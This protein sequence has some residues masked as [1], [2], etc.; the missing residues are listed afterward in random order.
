MKYIKFTYFLILFFLPFSGRSQVPVQVTDSTKQH[1]FTF[2]EI[3]MLVDPDDNYSFEE[4]QSDEFRTK[5]KASIAN[6]PQTLALNTNYWF[7][8]SIEGSSHLKNNFI[9]EFFDQTI[10]EITVYT[11]LA[12]GRYNTFKIGDH[13]PFGQRFL[14]HKNFEIPL[15]FNQGTNEQV[16]YFKIKSSQISDVIIVLRSV[17]FF[18]AYALNE[19]FSFGIFYGMILVFSL[20]NLIL[21]IS[22]RQKQYLFYVLYLLSVAL[23]EMSSDGIAYQYLWPNAPNWNQIAFAFTLI[24]ASS[25][26]LLFT[27]ELFHFKERVPWIYKLILYTLGI[28]AILFIYSLAFNQSFFNYKFIEFI[29]LSVAFFAG[30]YVYF[31]G[32][33]AARFFVIGYGFIFIGFTIKLLIMLGI[34]QLNF[35]VIG[36]YSLSICFILEMIFFSLA[37]GDNLRILKIKQQKMQKQVLKQMTENAALKDTLNRE[38]KSEVRKRNQELEIANMQLQQQ[39]EEIFRMNKLLQL[40]KEELQHDKEELLT[41]VKKISRDRAL[42]AEVD[43]EEFSA[44]YPDA[45]SCYEFLSELKWE[46]G[47][48]CRKCANT[49]YFKGNTPFSRRCTKCGYDESVTSYT[50]FHNSRIPINKSFYMTFL[51]YSTK[52][53]ISSHKLSEMVSIRQSTCWSFASRIKKTIADKKKI[54]K[55]TNNHG[56]SQLVLEEEV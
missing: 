6:T 52:G 51:I 14:K 15:H 28:R 20:Y 5:F 18:I 34:P 19:Y 25:F 46:N 56:W 44:A 1:I 29:P 30:L 31:K 47:Y 22:V 24:S 38:L 41:N 49:N 21:F 3:E 35:G 39:A 23:F 8:I 45:D 36:Y 54:M 2:T 7:K 9:L 32:Y 40:D 50:I 37:I 33:K 53:K 4:I 11:P 48:H 17:N 26:A 12:D 55:S 10:D 16:Y 13:L 27:R 43:F 42:S